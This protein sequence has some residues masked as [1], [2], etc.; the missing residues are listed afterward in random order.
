MN[1]YKLHEPIIRVVPD[2][3]G[4]GDRVRF[5]FTDFKNMRGI[6][7][8]VDQRLNTPENR[9]LLVKWDDSGETHSVSRQVLQRE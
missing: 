9:L 7:V 5:N 4:F 1:R 3:L 8:G 6:V 2:I